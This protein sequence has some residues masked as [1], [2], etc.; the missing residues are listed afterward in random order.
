MRLLVASFSPVP[1]SRPSRARRPLGAVSAPGPRQHS[2]PVPWAVYVRLKSG[3]RPS[4]DCCAGTLFNLLCLPPS[5]SWPSV[6]IR[7]KGDRDGPGGA[8]PPRRRG[9][10]SKNTCL[11]V[12]SSFPVSS[13]RP[14][15]ARRPLG[16]VSA[17][18]PRQHSS[19]V[20]WAVHVR[21]KIFTP[22]AHA[23]HTKK[24]LPAEGRGSV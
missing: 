11:L 10:E 3:S 15:R 23:T 12:V 7:A 8:S 16:A 1:S 17:L 6:A 20:P 21:L 5:P 22:A 14:S 13:S 4:S 24:P 19:P 2:S 9:R 18:G